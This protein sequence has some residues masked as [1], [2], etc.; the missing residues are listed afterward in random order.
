MHLNADYRKPS[1]RVTERQKSKTK[2]ERRVIN[3]VNKISIKMF[4]H[5]KNSFHNIS[6]V[7]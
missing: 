3:I 2:P 1:E 4:N 7:R 6:I 5:L